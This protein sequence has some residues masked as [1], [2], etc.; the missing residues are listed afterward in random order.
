MITV[1]QLMQAR[2]EMN[3]FAVNVNDTV[4]RALELMADKNI[5]AVLV[6]DQDH[7]VGIFSERDFVRKIIHADRCSLQTLVKEI[8]TKAMITIDPE[9]SID[10]CMQLMTRHHIRHLPVLDNGRLV[11]MVS[12]RDVVEAIINAKE[13]TISNLENYILGRDYGK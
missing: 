5:G 12:M 7:M 1:R 3:A 10:E 4:A 8:M 9:Q 13:D 2:G 11:G 6:T